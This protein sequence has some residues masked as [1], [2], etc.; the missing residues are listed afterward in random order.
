MRINLADGDADSPEPYSDD[1][2]QG[3]GDADKFYAVWVSASLSH[4]LS[5]EKAVECLVFCF[6][7]ITGI[8]I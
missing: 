8:A 3:E 4:L 2:G 1:L 7:M 6:T 5:A